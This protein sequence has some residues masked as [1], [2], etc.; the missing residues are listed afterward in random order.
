[1]KYIALFEVP[2]DIKPDV[3]S[4]SV[5]KKDNVTSVPYN[6]VLYT[7][8]PV[9]LPVPKSTTGKFKDGYDHSLELNYIHG[10]NDCICAMLGEHSNEQK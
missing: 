2:D 7:T 3:A 9:P 5:L 1:M 6:K 4:I 8:K 10:W